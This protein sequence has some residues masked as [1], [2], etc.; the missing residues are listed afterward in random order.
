MGSW[1]GSRMLINLDLHP[2]VGELFPVEI[3]GGQPSLLV[4]PKHPFTGAAHISL[5]GGTLL[6]YCLEKKPQPGMQG[7]Q[8]QHEGTVLTS[9][10]MHISDQVGPRLLANHSMIQTCERLLPWLLTI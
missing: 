6:Y 5:L 10:C 2:A 8:V 9:V 4:G 7:D 3:Q 1:L